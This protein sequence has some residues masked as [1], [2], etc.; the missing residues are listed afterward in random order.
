MLTSVSKDYYADARVH[1]RRVQAD[2][3]LR[4]SDVR[5]RGLLFTQLQVVLTA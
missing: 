1:E 2:T 5:K 4:W 3:T